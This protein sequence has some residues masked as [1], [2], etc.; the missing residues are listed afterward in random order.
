MTQYSYSYPDEAGFLY[1]LRMY[2][3]GNGNENI[4]FLLSKAQCHFSCSDSYTQ[5]EW[6]TFWL[7][8]DFRVPIPQLSK[9][10]PEVKKTIEDA[11]RVVFPP[12]AGYILSS[13]YVAPFIESPPEE[14]IT[15]ANNGSLGS[16]GTI[17]YDKLRFRSKTET[18]IYDALKRASVLFFP[19][20]TAVLGGK[21]EKREPDFLV[22]KDGKWGILEVMGDQYHPPSTAMRDHDRARLFKDY[23]L[24]C[25]E[26]YD[27]CQ[28]YEKPDEVVADFLVRLSRL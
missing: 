3:E 26:F 22:C 14:E 18:R 4:S 20:A 25:I 17:E 7:Y 16:V 10:T 23:G 8:I 27:A 13:I 5:V 12:D 6:D 11:I 1:T 19:N 24:I 2:L 28:C 21:D 15:A 9:F